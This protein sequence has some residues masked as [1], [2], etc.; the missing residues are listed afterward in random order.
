MKILQISRPTVYNYRKEG[1]LK[2]TLLPNNRWDY[3]LFRYEDLLETKAK[4]NS[5]TYPRGVNIMLLSE[6]IQVKK[7]PALSKVCH[8]AKNLFNLANFHYRQ[9]FF[10]L[11][12]FL[13]Y[14]DL[15]V[16]LKDHSAYKA[17]PAQSSQ[18]ILKLVI[19]NWKSYWKAL[20]EYRAN[21]SKFLGRPKLPKYKR[22]DGESICI[23]TNQNT[24][25]K[26]GCIHFPKKCNFP[27]LKTRIEKYQQIRLIPKG[28]YY[29]YEIIY[30]REE[31]DMNLDKT[32]NLSIDLGVD[33]LLTTAN[34]I[35]VPPLIVKGK[36][37]KSIN[38]WINF[39]FCLNS[40][41]FLHDYR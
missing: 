26:N 5:R 25:V 16:I 31:I 29:I 28:H 10:N 38:Q 33:N 2:A 32:R 40:C 6:Q 14:Y 17:L 8:L 9:F 18:Q 3:A 35:G 1:K 24:R 12:E 22:K 37:I 20:E 30:N 7:T 4:S 15:Q 13:N 41:Q 21:P 39:V 34:N 11:E 19:R 36:V 27:P 23:F